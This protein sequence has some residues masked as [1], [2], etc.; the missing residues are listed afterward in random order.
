MMRQTRF[1]FLLLALAALVAGCSSSTP[2]TPGTAADQAKTVISGDIAPGTPAFA[3]SA[4]APGDPSPGTFRIEGSNLRY[5]TDPGMLLADIVLVN[6]SSADFA[7][8]VR[9]VF[10]QLLPAG[11]TVLN[12]DAVDSTQGAGAVF[13]FDLEDTTG[14]W[15]AGER[16]LPRT[17]QFGV[18][19]GTSIAFVSRIVTGDDPAPGGAIGGTVFADANGNGLR[20]EGEQGV[21]DVAIMLHDGAAVD[22]TSAIMQAMTDSTGAYRFDAL[23]SGHYTVALARDPRIEPTTA[24]VLDVLLVEYDGQVMDFLGA[25]FGVRRAGAPVDTTFCLAAGDC[26]E[27]KGMFRPDRPRLE[28]WELERCDEGGTCGD[29]DGDDADDDGDHPACWS[30]LC[31]PITAMDDSTGAIA[32]MGTWIELPVEALGR[33]TR[34]ED[35][36]VGRRVRVEVE[37][38]TG[39][40]GDHL[41]ACRIQKWNGNGDRVRGVIQ[42]VLRDPQ[43]HPALRVLNTVVTVPPS[44]SCAPDSTDDDHDD[45]D[46]R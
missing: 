6:D 10:M 42:E 41:R 39:D 20:D 33:H 34:P 25:D 36:A 13:A 43:G 30:R 32:V 1:M 31:G 17:V 4:A 8:P 11:V 19:P 22:S 15:R 35:I 7:G 24:P 2:T 28:A 29:D 3:F 37:V 18:A 16:T 46:W 9:L 23:A 12:A 38:M 14:T 21:R 27:A 5:V 44:F 26:I 45:D 40:A